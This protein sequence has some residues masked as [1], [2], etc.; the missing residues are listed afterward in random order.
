LAVAASAL[1]RARLEAVLEL[2][3]GAVDPTDFTGGIAQFALS[4]ALLSAFTRN[5]RIRA[6]CALFQQLSVRAVARASRWCHCG[7]CVRAL[8]PLCSCALALT[9]ALPHIGP[10]ML[11]TARTAAFVDGNT[12]NPGPLLALDA[13]LSG[14]LAADLEEAQMRFA[15]QE[16]KTAV[17]ALTT[18]FGIGVWE[19]GGIPVLL[20]GAGEAGE[21]VAVEAVARMALPDAARWIRELAARGR[22]ALAL[23]MAAPFPE[24]ELRKVVTDASAVLALW[25]G[26]KKE[27]E[28]A[29]SAD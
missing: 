13:V 17:F 29:K 11:A 9:G 28:E 1:P 18:I 19:E 23:R 8:P 16:F 2:I 5:P 25:G 22:V 24:A 4:C 12:L 6:R 14:P 10:A 7:Y 3:S 15:R 20:E 27:D 21:A 26:E